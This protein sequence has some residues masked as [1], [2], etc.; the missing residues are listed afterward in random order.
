MLIL[1]R[2]VGE[3]ICIGEDIKVTV[4]QVR[5]NQVRIGIDAPK[6]TNIR[7]EELLPRA[8]DDWPGIRTRED[9]RYI[10]PDTC[11]CDRCNSG[12]RHRK[13]AP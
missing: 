13:A 12:F 4:L 10:H 3:A 8:A 11:T 5:G 9:G 6:T 1:T 7:R 2:K